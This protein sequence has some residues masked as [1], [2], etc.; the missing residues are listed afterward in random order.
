MAK[1]K[2]HI[3]GLIHTDKHPTPWARMILC[4]TC[5]SV[6]LLIGYMR[7]QL[8]LS[9]Y[10]ALAGYLL[11]INDHLGLLRHRVI[12]VSLTFLVLLLGFAA[13]FFLKDSPITFQM[14]VGLVVYWLGILG[15]DGD[16]LERGVLFAVLAMIIAF[17][18]KRIQLEVVRPIFSYCLLS[19]ASIL[20]GI[21]ALQLIY[22]RTPEPYTKIRKSFLKSFQ[23][24]IEKHIY[25]TSYTCATLLAT[26]LAIYFQIE[27]GYWI[28][29]TVLLVMRADRKQ[30]IYKTLQRLIGTA[31]AVLICDLLLPREFYPL[32]LISIIALSAFLVP[33]GLKNNYLFASFFVTILILLLLEVASIKHGDTTVAFFRLRATLIGCTLSLFATFASKLFATAYAR[34]SLWY[35]KR[36]A[37]LSENI[38][39]S[40][41]V[42]DGSK[43][44]R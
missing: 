14:S 29:I 36:S 32:I 28:S 38:S 22:D 33:I 21:P 39:F 6:P 31:C 23:P 9:I 15:G 27:R 13:G 3:V 41:I 37:A 25:A 4:A 44:K 40:M 1:L 16:E 19:L 7:G 18:T 34:N 30:S 11:A 10:G 2:S 26:W 12:V 8:G 17:A 5:T 20:V 24:K 42:T 43:L 35:L